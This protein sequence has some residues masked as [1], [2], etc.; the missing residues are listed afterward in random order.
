MSIFTSN[1]TDTYLAAPKKAPL[2]QTKK[3]RLRNSYFFPK[4]TS[5]SLPVLALNG[6]G[7]LVLLK[8]KE[9]K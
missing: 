1:A 2:L 7:N 9:V 4:H 6:S 8:V 3:S 5:R